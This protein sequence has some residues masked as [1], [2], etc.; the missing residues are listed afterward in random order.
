MTRRKSLYRVNVVVQMV[1]WA[2]SANTNKLT[3]IP[4]EAGI[5]Y[6]VLLGILMGWGWF[7][8]TLT[9]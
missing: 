8:R 5:Y 7:K 2:G 3:L 6:F 9:A 1:Q 4:Y